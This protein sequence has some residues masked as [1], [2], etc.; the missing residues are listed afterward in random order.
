M[1]ILVFW[2]LPLLAWA[3]AFFRKFA[4]MFFFLTV[5]NYNTWVDLPALRIHSS[6]TF[7]GSFFMNL[8]LWL[9]SNNFFKFLE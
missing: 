8:A 5:L 7:T 9:Y 4:F 2:G 1:K 3:T 6:G